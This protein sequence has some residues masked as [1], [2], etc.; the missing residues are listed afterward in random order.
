MISLAFHPFR[1][2]NVLVTLMELIKVASPLFSFQGLR[3]NQRIE[4]NLIP[5]L[6]GSEIME[7][8]VAG[9]KCKKCQAK[10]NNVASAGSPSISLLAQALVLNKY[11]CKLR[12]E[13][14]FFFFSHFS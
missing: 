2:A 14:K 3:L 7:G 9:A 1:V 4:M 12:R 6:L 13:I 5:G 11:L 10:S 8:K